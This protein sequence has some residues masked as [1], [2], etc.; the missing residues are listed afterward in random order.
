MNILQIFVVT[1]P[2]LPKCVPR[3]LLHQLQM[4]PK[5][6]RH[7]VQNNPYLSQNQPHFLPIQSLCSNEL[8]ESPYSFCMWD[9]HKHM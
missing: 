3:A 8:K 5:I 6:V 7:F 1:Y 9:P 2:Q 4:N